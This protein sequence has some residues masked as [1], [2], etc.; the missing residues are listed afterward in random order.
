MAIGGIVGSVCVIPIEGKSLSAT[1]ARGFGILAV[2]GVGVG[3]LSLSIARKGQL[4]STWFWIE[5]NQTY[6][7]RRDW[8]QG[9]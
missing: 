1:W 8:V 5:A 9:Q 3:A 4:T 6:R 2:A 7:Q